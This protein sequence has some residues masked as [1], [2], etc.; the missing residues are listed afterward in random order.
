M[1]A[2]SLC[3]SLAPKCL[4]NLRSKTRWT[5]Q[6]PTTCLGIPKRIV[7]P[8][9]SSTPTWKASSRTTSLEA[10]LNF[11]LTPPKLPYLRTNKT[12]ASLSTLQKETALLFHASC[13]KAITWGVTVNLSHLFLSNLDNPITTQMWFKQPRRFQTISETLALHLP[14]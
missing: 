14:V 9:Q 7:I 3:A 8:K 11:V 4:M 2:S 10:T 1:L 6:N 5:C 12:S 13:W